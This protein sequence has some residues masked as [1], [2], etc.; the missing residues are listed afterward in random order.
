MKPVRV[1]DES[2]ISQIYAASRSN[3]NIADLP[4][5]EPSLFI[6]SGN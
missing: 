6:L 3:I 5:I 2:S 4:G 1:L